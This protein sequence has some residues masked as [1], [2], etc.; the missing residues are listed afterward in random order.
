MLLTLACARSAAA[1]CITVYEPNPI[2]RMRNSEYVYLARV[3]EV[4]TRMAKVKVIRSWKGGGS[5]FTWTGCHGG[6]VGEYYLVYADEPNEQ[7][8]CEC[9]ERAIPVRDAKTEMNLL[10]RH[11]GFPRLVLEL[12]PSPSPS[13]RGN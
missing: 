9:G 2:L 7:F 6:K 4:E 8:D 13:P 10:N 12:P 5:E 1:E 11:R 3:T